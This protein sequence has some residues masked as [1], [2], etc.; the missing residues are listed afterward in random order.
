MTIS[1]SDRDKKLLIYLGAVIIIAAA[2]TTTPAI[3]IN[4]HG[5]FEKIEPTALSVLKT[6][7]LPKWF[8]VINAH[9]PF[10]GSF[11]CL[12]TWPRVSSPPLAI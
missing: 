11:T 10:T 6:K 2:I 5:L 4:T 12:K 7:Q 1:M 3:T 9:T 8:N